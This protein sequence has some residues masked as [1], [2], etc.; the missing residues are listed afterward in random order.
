MGSGSRSRKTTAQRHVPCCLEAVLTPESPFFIVL[1]AASGS[2]SAEEARTTIQTELEAAGRKHEFFLAEKGSQ[3]SELAQRAAARASAE[4]GA[5][6]AAGG[7]GTINAVASA[8]LPTGR[9]LGIIP[10]GT[11][12]FTTRARGI[13]SDTAEATRALSSARIVPQQVGTVNDRVFLVNSSVGLY[14]QLLED[15][16]AYKARYGRYRAVAFWSGLRTLLRDHRQ[17]SLEIEHDGQRERTRTPAL[18]IGNNPLQFEQAGLEKAEAEVEHRRL[19]AVVVKPL[20]TWALVMLGLR[21]ALGQLGNDDNVREFPFRHMVVDVARGR[22]VKVATDGEVTVMSSP[23]KF[24][25]APQRLPLLVP[26]E[27]RK[28]E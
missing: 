5:V 23:L 12:N 10:Q 15:R 20:S 22:R 3:V 16:E 25:I 17:L 28:A 7:D 1:N 8:T 6:I 4:N 13:P 9:P 2:G 14:A 24:G 21:G 18:F 27:P 11:F 26:A 19:A